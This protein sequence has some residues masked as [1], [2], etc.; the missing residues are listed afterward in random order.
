MKIGNDASEFIIF[1]FFKLRII[2]NYGIFQI[3]TIQP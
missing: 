1:E 2:F 3:D